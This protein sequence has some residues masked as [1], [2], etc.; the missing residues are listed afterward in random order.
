[1]DYHSSDVF[2]AIAGDSGGAEI[3]ALDVAGDRFSIT[4]WFVRLI[5][6][7]HIVWP[8]PIDCHM[9]P[10]TIVPALEFAAQVGQ[11]IHA[12]DK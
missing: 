4:L 5:V 8:K 9:R 1:M 6:V 10:P 2:Q 12:S 7:I 11:M 3:A